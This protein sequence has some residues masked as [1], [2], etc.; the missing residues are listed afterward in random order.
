METDRASSSLHSIL[1]PLGVHAQ[2]IDVVW[3]TMMWVCTIMYAIVLV[4]FALALLRR[5][6]QKTLDE[7]HAESRRFSVSLAVWAVLVVLGLFGL[8]LTS[9][10]TD[11]AI[12]RAAAQPQVLL[13]LTAH[14][15]W[16]EIEY[17]NSDP[18]QRFRT[19]NEIHLPVNAQV[20]IELTANDV[21]HSFW[22]PNLHGKRDLIP[23]RTNE[24]ALQPQQLGV[25]R[26]QC[27]EYCG[28]QHAH[29]AIDVVVEP[30]QAFDR[31]RELQLAV[32]A[33]PSDALT[34]RGQRVFME[35]ACNMCHA[36]SGTPAFGQ[37]GPDLSH[38]A[39]R[40]MLAAGRVDNTAENLKR[41]LAN[42]QALKPGNRMPIVAL[43][44]A[45][46]EALV[47]YLG[48]LR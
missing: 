21:I 5:R 24:I 19:A 28:V 6:S 13:K 45:Q 36:I 37:T 32:A 1:E 29:M 30:Q 42:P 12:V 39:S 46:L 22:V 40:R 41:W 4:F 17:L 23:G 38:V 16:W 14:Q 2:H 27:A 25:F 26:G 47:A 44:E 33:Q 15:W 3:D 43:D 8:T 48:A 10:L 20:L 9:F 18:S 11:R 35:T 34:Q 31:W 7:E